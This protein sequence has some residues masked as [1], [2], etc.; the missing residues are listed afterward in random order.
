MQVANDSTALVAIVTGASRGAG[1][2]IAKTLASHGE[3][4]VVNYLHST[5]LARAVVTEIEEQGGSAMA[6]Q[7]DVTDVDATHRMAN[8]VIERYGR[9]D[10][11]VNNAGLFRT[12]S[13]FSTSRQDWLDAFSCNI[14][15]IVN[16]TLSCAPYMKLDRGAVVNIGS[17]AGVYPSSQALAYSVSKAGVIALTK[18]LAAELG[19]RI[20]VNCILPGF[21]KTDMTSTVAEE[22]QTARSEV[23]V[24][25]R[26]CMPQDVANA[27]V[28]LAYDATYVTGQT[29]ILDG[30]MFL[31]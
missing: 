6:C 8:K 11:L 31:S 23:T 27:V 1:V 25:K 30:G 12:G 9:I 24:L 16:C 13:L 7:A 14:L 5:S 2:V 3:H 4:V 18:A 22:A 29:L 17:L 21:M 28:Y 20:R 15:G 26:L 10:I 19:P